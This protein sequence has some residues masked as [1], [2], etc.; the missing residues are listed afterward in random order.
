MYNPTGGLD[1]EFVELHNPSTTDS[2]DISGWRMDGV[3]LTIPSGTVILPQGYALFVKNDV[4][5]RVE[6]GSGKFIAAQYNGSL[7]DLGE[8]L[9]TPQFLAQRSGC[10]FRLHGSILPGFDGAP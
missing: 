3:A 9:R 5:F 10:P 4:Q 8:S 7:D 2:V 6:Y 1:H